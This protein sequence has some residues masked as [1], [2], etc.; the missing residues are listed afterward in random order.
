MDVADA[1][2]VFFVHRERGHEDVPTVWL[3]SDRPLHG[4]VWILAHECAHFVSH[5]LNEHGTAR[6][7]EATACQFASVLCALLRG[8]YEADILRHYCSAAHLFREPVKLT[9][10][11]ILRRVSWLAE[12]AHLAKAGDVIDGVQAL[13]IE[14]ILDVP[15]FSEGKLLSEGWRIYAEWL[16]SLLGIVQKLEGLTAMLDW[17]PLPAFAGCAR[18]DDHVEARYR[19]KGC[20]GWPT[21]LLPWCG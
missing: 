13:G 16:G 17:K 6:Q 21:R 7:S 1:A 3:K 8:Q 2:G 20:P 15:E 4:R 10:D 11:R 14:R 9:V 5:L 12:Q 18:I 19:G